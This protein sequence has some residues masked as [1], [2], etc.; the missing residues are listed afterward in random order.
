MAAGRAGAIVITEAT[1]RRRIE[2]HN[3][4]QLLTASI[5]FAGAALLWFLSFWLFRAL[6]YLPLAA[7]GF[8]AWGC[9]FYAAL[10]VLALLTFETLRFKGPP[11]ELEEYSESLFG[12]SILAQVRVFGMSGTRIAGSPLA[13]VFLVVKLVFAAPR[14]T[15]QAITA[16]RSRIQAEPAVIAQAVQAFQKLDLAHYWMR[17][18]DFPGLGG[19][20]FLLDRL[21]M[22][23]TKIEDGQRMVR[24][25]AGSQSSDFQ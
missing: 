8:D 14:A 12:D 9:S 16:L 2:R 18:S 20:L 4:I 5:L 15:V 1:L 11:V 22:L 3:S 7:F 21:D 10:A 24:I 17:A 13:Y 19:G 25:P 6:I 23:W